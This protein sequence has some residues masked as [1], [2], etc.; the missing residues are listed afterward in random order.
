MGSIGVSKFKDPNHKPL[1]LRS[2]G[3]SFDKDPKYIKQIS[4]QRQPSLIEELAFGIWGSRA[5][6]KPSTVPKK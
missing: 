2:I 3:V 4:A 5:R 1:L 6:A